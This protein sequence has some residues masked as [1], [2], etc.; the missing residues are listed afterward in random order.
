MPWLRDWVYMTEQHRV[1]K[2]GPQS[3][4]QPSESLADHGDGRV[5][6]AVYPEGRLD[7]ADALR[8][9]LGEG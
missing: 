7:Q 6:S 5:L 3:G 8:P 1:L 4:T 2:E 9:L